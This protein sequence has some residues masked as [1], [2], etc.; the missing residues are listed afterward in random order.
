M[1]AELEKK[2][3]ECKA[4]LDEA[5]AVSDKLRDEL[6]GKDKE[7]DAEKEKNAVLTTTVTEL[8]GTL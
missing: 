6:A 2:E 7:V 8:E 3:E 4:E 5:N 1:K